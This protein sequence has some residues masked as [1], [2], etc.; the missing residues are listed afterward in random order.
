LATVTNFITDGSVTWTAT[1]GTID[2]NGLYTAGTTAGTFTVTA[3]SVEDRTQS[4]SATVTIAALPVGQFV[5]LAN[6]T[7]LIV[8]TIQRLS[9]TTSATR[10]TATSRFS[11]SG[12]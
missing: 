6:G 7:R 2:P 11:G 8:L 4:A 10:I 5:G 1:G 3:T 12:P 9:G